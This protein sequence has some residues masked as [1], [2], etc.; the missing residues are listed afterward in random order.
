MMS[1]LGEINS[2]LAAIK[3]NE[4]VKH[5][6]DNIQKSL[7]RI[8]GV[9]MKFMGLAKEKSAKAFVPFINA[10][11]VLEML[12]D[13]MLAFLLT[14]QAAIA[15]VKFKAIC[16]EKGAADP[17]A[18]AALLKEHADAKFYYGKLKTAEFFV[19]NLLPRTA[20]KEACINNMDTSCMED[21][22]PQMV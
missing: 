18:V 8:N 9:V 16:A 20:W 2:R 11:D 17:K 22:F 14:E 10:C 7:D 12:G 19:N 15:Q 5:L 21:I 1:F 3:K 6:A 4:D 13:F